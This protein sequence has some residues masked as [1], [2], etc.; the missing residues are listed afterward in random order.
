MPIST[1][2]AIEPGQIHHANGVDHKPREM[3]LRQP[4]T[5]IR[6]QKKRLLTIGRQ[7]VLGHAQIVLNPPD[8]TTLYATASRES[9]TACCRT[10]SADSSFAICGNA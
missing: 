10:H 8:N 3:L 6:R 9:D 2:R 4:L 1:I 7:E 5:R